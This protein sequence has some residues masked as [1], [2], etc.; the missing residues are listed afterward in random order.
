MHWRVGGGG[1]GLELKA[2]SCYILTL[3]ENY[4]TLQHYYCLNRCGLYSMYLVKCMVISSD[5][6]SEC[7]Q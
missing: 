1:L 6:L 4:H 3:L 5:N 2:A 7:I